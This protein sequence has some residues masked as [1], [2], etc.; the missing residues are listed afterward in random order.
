MSDTEPLSPTSGTAD[1][2][3][4]ELA[5]GHVFDG[6]YEIQRR[7]GSGGMGV[8]YTARR[9]ILDDIVALKQLAPLSSSHYNKTR[10]LLEARA[11]AHI[12]HPNVVEIFDFGEPPEDAPYIVM[13]YLEGPTLAEVLQRGRLPVERALEIFAP[14]CA[15]IE[16]GHRRGIVHRDLKPANIIL[17]KS[18]DGRE[19]LK[20]L[21]FGLAYVSIG[22]ASRLTKTGAIVGTAKYMA[23]EQARGEDVVP[24]TDIFALGILLYEMVTGE[25]PFVAK[26]PILTALK[27]SQGEYTPPDEI[28]PSLP[29]SIVQAIH[30]ALRQDPTKR[31]QSAE[32]LARMAEGPM[33]ARSGNA[34]ASQTSG[35]AVSAEPAASEAEGAGDLAFDHFVGRERQLRRLR[36]EYEKAAGGSGRIVLVTGDAGIGKTRMVEHFV[37]QLH[38][39]TTAVVLWCR[40]FDYA[41]SRPPAF[42]S[43]LESLHHSGEVDAVQRSVQQ[44]LE[45]RGRPGS[46]DQRWRIFTAFT[47]AFAA[48]AAGRPLVL[49]FDDIHWASNTDLDLIDHLQRSLAKRG[50]LVIATAREGESRT[51][52]QADLGGW[53]VRLGARR[54]HAVLGLQPFDNR[55]IRSWLDQGFGHIRI[56]PHDVKRIGQATGANPYCVAEVARQLVA[57]GIIDWQEGWYCQPLDAVE[58]PET[59]N[60]LVRARLRNLDQDTLEMLEVA[61]VIGDE[62]RFETLQ[63]AT[64]QREDLLEDLIE[65]ACS[66]L[67]LTDDG[68]SSGNDYRFRTAS[69]RQVLYGDLPRSKRRRAH[70]QVVAALHALYHDDLER[71]A[72]ILAYHHHAVG[73][74]QETL[75][76]SLHALSDALERSDNDAAADVQQLAA[77]AL[78]DAAAVTQTER[79]HFD[80]L[81]GILYRRLGRLEAAKA[82]LLR[83]VEPPVEPALGLAA[84]LELARCHLD[85]G[86]AEAAVAT[87]RR[88]EQAAGEQHSAELQ[89]EARM[90]RASCWLRLGQ[91][92]RAAQLLDRLLAELGERSS[93]SLR[94]RAHRER[95]WALLKSGAFSE[96][97]EHGRRALELAR[98]AGDLLAQHHALSAQAAVR[99]ESGDPAGAVPLHRRAL[100]LARRLS[101]R[102]R[103]A[104]DLANL[105]EQ[106]YELCDPQRALMDFKKALAIFVEIGDRA[107]EGDC[108]VNLGRAMLALGDGSQ[109]LAMLQRGRAQCEATGRTEYTGLALLYEGQAHLALEDPVA[110]GA[111]YAQAQARFAE[112]RSH[113]LWRADLGRAQA[114]SAEGDQA[115]ALQMA[116]IAAQRVAAQRSQLPPEGDTSGF[117]QA[118]QA[119]YDLLAKLEPQRHRPR[120]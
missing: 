79:D 89:L 61:A 39:K 12:R 114:A 118:S 44:A 71:Q 103:E 104:I 27:I 113:Y 6:R 40:F 119:V 56:H 22:S 53:I 80:H 29:R 63:L 45:I 70:R 50:T 92:E 21:D 115:T 46:D 3:T 102:R 14:I 60:N 111:A 7:I 74:W 75:T 25:L 1:E 51:G 23:P 95:A 47:E 41:G 72:P 107:C 93:A 105:G 35:T 68:V 18:D 85:L 36:E 86:D 34:A 26:T 30:R 15:A 10:F 58:L 42:E 101:L 96:A 106:Y 62:V 20:V 94:S 49:V 98:L 19:V 59:V 16:A 11:A 116:R 110:A 24:S 54:A 9:L 52:S 17:A 91:S 84:Q 77:R 48:R 38:A 2:G 120:E 88:A 108:R 90:L 43:F 69:S 31:P 33:N 82:S 100:E 57:D 32:Q 81:T 83:T 73:D 65:R 37:D 99:G 112:L 109:A 13:E 67:L 87:T 55:E 66:Q 28:V 76:W 4:R 64:G 117:E 5:R 78:T 97:Q 8:V